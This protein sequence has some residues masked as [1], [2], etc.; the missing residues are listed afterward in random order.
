MPAAPENVDMA[1][2][3]LP[4]D[5]PDPLT[6]LQLPEP[7]DGAL[8]PRVTVVNPQVVAPVCA[9]PALAVVG[10]AFTVMVTLEAEDEQGEL[11][12][13]QV[14]TYAPAPP[15]GVKVADGFV[16]LVN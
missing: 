14:K 6:T 12:I 2:D 16:V 4:N 8:A 13:V 5:P 3:T 9:G 10:N 1:L 7:T 11:L 15:A